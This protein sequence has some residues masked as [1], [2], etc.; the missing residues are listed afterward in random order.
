[1]AKNKK[2]AR[3]GNQKRTRLTL[4]QKLYILGLLKKNVSHVEI[5][6]SYN[7]GESTV[8]VNLGIIRGKPVPEAALEA[9]K[10]WAVSDEQ[11]NI[12]QALML[13]ARRTSW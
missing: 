8:I 1:M 2:S 7:C 12:L 13:D 9:P 3:G 11:E 10:A 6:R 4:G 5:A